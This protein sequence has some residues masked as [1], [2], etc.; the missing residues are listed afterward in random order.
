MPNYRF[1]VGQFDVLMI[2]DGGAPRA[3]SGWLSS[4]PQH[5]LREVVQQQGLDPEAVDSSITPIVVTG[6]GKTVLI[7]T[8]IG[9][10]REGNIPAHL[11]E[12][13][14]KPDDIGLIVIT[15]GHGDHVGGIVDAN[16]QFTYPNARYTVWSTE[17]EYWTADDRF[18]EADNNNPAKA[19]WGALKANPQ[20]VTRIGSASQQEAEILPGMCAVATPGHT[21]GHIAVELTSGDDKLLHVADA[22]HH[23]FQLAR[24][25]WSPNF[26]YDPVQSAATRK[27]ILERAARD[28]SLFSAYHFPF[29]GVGRVHEQNGVFTWEQVGKL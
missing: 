12:E 17:W 26:D 4:A 11:Q 13:G 27:Q 8:G 1:K 5:E 20:L 14:L 21:I 29:P 10:G 15:H 28:G 9:Y 22:V 25:Q 23:W 6:G 3:A 24:P 2:K 18:T 16:G 7:D 19:A